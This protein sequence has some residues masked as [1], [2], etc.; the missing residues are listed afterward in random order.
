MLLAVP[1]PS[2]V[3]FGREIAPIMA[4]HCNSCHGE[5]G[6]LS[7]RSYADLMRG[8]NLGAVI[9]PGNA[10]GSLL[11]YFLDGRRGDQHRMPQGGRPLSAGQ[12]A[13]IRRW[14][15][16][17]A[18]DDDAQVKSYRLTRPG[19]R[20]ERGKI[21]RVFCRVN[22]AAYLSV[23]MRDPNDGR[24]LWS[25]VA[26]VK[27]PKEGGDAGEP[28]QT[29]TWDLRAGTGW[30]DVVTLELSIEY[31]ASEPRGTE[32]YARPAEE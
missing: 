15:D 23:T 2:P 3:S 17:G 19:V 13:T 28:G 20:M 26:S 18:T 30:P 32:F 31:A 16:E 10:D 1:P 7:T 29:I 12:I 8:G 4:L 6:G 24:L 14:I 25:E 11:I 9:V 27:K 22:T 21:T 5:A